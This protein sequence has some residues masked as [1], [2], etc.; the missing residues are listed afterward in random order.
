MIMFI[1]ENTEKLMR[2]YMEIRER[3]TE[4]RGMHMESWRHC[5]TVCLLSECLLLNAK[6][7][8]SPEFTTPFS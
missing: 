2:E 4:K 6:C 3:L 1:H 5:A 8:P 7:Y